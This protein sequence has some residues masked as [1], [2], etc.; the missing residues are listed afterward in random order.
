[1]T[2][3]KLEPS[4]EEWRALYGAAK[5][6]MEIRPWT[7]MA[8]SDL[9]GVQNALN[10]EIGYCCVMGQLEEVFALAVYR[11]SD[12]LEGYLRMQAGEIN[13]YDPDIMHVQ[14]CL[15]A[16]FEGRDGLEKEDLQAIKELG[17]KFRGRNAWPQFRSYLP[18]YVPWFVTKEEAQFLTT[19]IEQATDVA[20]RFKEDE[21]LL[22]PS[23]E[24]QLLVRVPVPKGERVEWRDEWIFPPP[25]EERDFPEGKVDQLTIRRI[26]KKVKNFEGTWEVDFFYFPRAVEEGD[27]PY[28]PYTLLIA[29]HLSGMIL[30]THLTHSEDYSHEFQESILK[31][32]EETGT[33]PDR[34]LVSKPE[35]KKILEPIVGKMDI[36]VEMAERLEAVEEFTRAM[37]S[38]FRTS[39]RI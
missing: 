31:F 23:K 3:K 38:Q 27:R 7:W 21:R 37:Y 4:L 9:F 13:E 1:M 36:S 6:F 34:I 35:S 39:G 8:D 22:M 19:A 20:L 5:D 29:D 30:H 26:K 25:P 11:G 2:S 18:G 32:M 17:F 28:F 24:G 16:S 12:G 15:M 33:L 10:G 14:K